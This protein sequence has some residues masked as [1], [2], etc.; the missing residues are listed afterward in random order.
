MTKGT[1]LSEFEK[2]E[3]TA[4]KKR[5]KFWRPYDALKPLSAITWKVQISIIGIWVA[6]L[7]LVERYKIF[8]LSNNAALS[9]FLYMT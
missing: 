3:I 5:E 2:G 8:L 4:L 9:H 1:E 6:I 7:F